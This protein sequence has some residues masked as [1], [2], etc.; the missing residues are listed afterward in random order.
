MSTEVTRPRCRSRGDTRVDSIFLHPTKTYASLERG[1]GYLP[2]HSPQS[3]D[4]CR[5]VR[6]SELE[7]MISQ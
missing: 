2:P 5:R 6:A 4:G 1:I 7:A 3:L